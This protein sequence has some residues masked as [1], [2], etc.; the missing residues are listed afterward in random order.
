MKNMKCVFTKP[1]GEKCKSFAMKNSSYCWTH[2]PEISVFEKKLGA[3]KGGRNRVPYLPVRYPEIIIKNSRDVPPVL[4]DT[5]YR[6]R[7]GEMDIRLGTAIGYIANVLLK[8][9]EVADLEVRIEKL[10][11]YAEENFYKEK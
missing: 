7:R 5:L 1:N 2:S 11:Q 8:A 6:L 4:V 3:S 9:Y 10:E